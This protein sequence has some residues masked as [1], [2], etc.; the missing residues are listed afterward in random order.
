MDIK[1]DWP[2]IKGKFLKHP[3]IR[4]MGTAGKKR[5]GTDQEIQNWLRIVKPFRFFKGYDLLW[6]DM[7][8]VRDIYFDE[9]MPLSA[10]EMSAELVQ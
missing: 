5:K 4:L 7:K 1:K 3:G 2:L 6:R 9:A 10:G 8:Y